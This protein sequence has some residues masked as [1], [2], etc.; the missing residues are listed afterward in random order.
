M[1]REIWSKRALNQ[2][3]RIVNFIK[4]DQ[5]PSYAKIVVNKVLSSTRIL[6]G[7]P[8]IGTV[9]PLLEHKKSEYRYLVVFSYNTR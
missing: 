2:L 7:T 4:E 1:V 8:Q 3:E 6:E 5:S 9:E